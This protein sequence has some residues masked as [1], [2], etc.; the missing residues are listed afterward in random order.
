MKNNN[1]N[2]F[3]VVQNILLVVYNYVYYNDN[4]I[5]TNI[6]TVYYNNIRKCLTLNNP[7]IITYSKIVFK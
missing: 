1:F 5:I 2:Y 3:N 4:N 7:S 6:I